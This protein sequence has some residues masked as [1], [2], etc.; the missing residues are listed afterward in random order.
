MSFDGT[1]PG[2]ILEL[3]AR[4]SVEPPKRSLP[5]KS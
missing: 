2:S 1:A 5:V 4:M 3:P